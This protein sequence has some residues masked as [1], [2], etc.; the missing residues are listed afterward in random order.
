VEFNG[1]AE[2]TTSN[3]G[4]PDNNAFDLGYH[5]R[6][7]GTGPGPVDN[8]YYV[9]I[10]GN[11]ERA[12]GRS[13]ADA[14]RSI[15]RALDVA[16]PGD[17]IIVGPGNYGGQIT[18]PF[19]GTPEEPIILSA[20]P[21][22]QLTEDSPAPV[23]I[24]AQ[25]VGF[26]LTQ[27]GYIIID[28]FEIVGAQEAGIRIR[29]RA[30][31]ITI[32]NCIVRDGRDGIRVEDSDDVLLFNNLV[33][34]NGQRGIVVERSGAVSVVN[35]TVSENFDRGIQ[36]GTGVLEAPDAFLQNNI[37]QDNGRTNVDFNDISAETGVLSHNLVFPGDYRPD[38]DELLPRPTDI[39]E[40]ALF[41]SPLTDNFRLL[42]DSP[43]IDAGDPQ[44]I[45][46]YIDELGK[47]TTKTD[48]LTD[49]APA[50]L[51]YHYPILPPLL[52]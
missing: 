43:A 13:P 6:T 8:V 40:D 33:T 26:Q 42:D 39:N 5:Y 10:A 16:T 32:R 34:F 37:V 44:T 48:E 38:V 29:N 46:A 17:T 23:F 15:R 11:D 52:P 20:D 31:N 25:V 27:A 2:R 7:E 3:T 49:S 14:F 4:E 30:F 45:R 51:G 22:G 24:S 9:R 28:G 12:S 47:R 41:V 18:F 21:T 35:N 19:S 50:D 1:L 36:I